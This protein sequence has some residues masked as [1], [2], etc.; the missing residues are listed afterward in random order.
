[1]KAHLPEPGRVTG[2]GG[3]LTPGFNA[4]LGLESMAGTDPLLSPYLYELTHAARL[5]FVWEW[6]LVVNKPNTEI[7]LPFYDL[8]NVRYYL[9]TVG[10]L[11]GAVR[12]LK[13]NG[14]RDLDVY[15]SPT[16][17]PRAFFTDTIAHYGSAEDFAKMVHG[18]DRRPLA[19]VQESDQIAASLPAGLA[20]RRV[21]PASDYRQTG[22]TTTF[23]IDAP[24]AGVAVLSETFEEGNFRVTI[25]GAPAPYFRVNHVFNG[26]LLPRA[27]RFTIAFSYW[28][29]LLTPALWL[30]AAGL[31]SLLA[32]TVLLWRT[33][34]PR[35]EKSAP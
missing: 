4:V 6:R 3:V 26:V 2:F 27:G 17:W 31:V 10:A 13:L 22:D 14:S 34:A 12:G 19:A 24:S 25:N 15:E 8:F 18:G 21:V 20:A 11:P 7:L 33:A 29:R 32:A 28:P 5:Q 23:T 1:V 30:S 16:V 9:G 35:E